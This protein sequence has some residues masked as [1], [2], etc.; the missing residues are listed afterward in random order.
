MRHQSGV[1]RL[2]APIR[3]RP[4]PTL[5]ALLGVLGALAVPP[6]AAAPKVH[7]S[8]QVL[9]LL[10]RECLSC[11]SGAAAPGGFSIE[12]AAKLFA[13]G[14]HGA[15]VVPGKSGES[16]LLKY[17][18]GEMK[19]QM[20][21]GKPLA[22]ETIGLLKRWIDEGARIDSFTAAPEKM[23]VMRDAMPMAAPSGRAKAAPSGRSALPAAVSQSAP[24]TAVAFS[25][26]GG[27]LA[28]G[29]YR[30]VRLLDSSTG[31]LLQT[32]KG[33]AGQ[34]LSLAW[35]SDGK[36]LA[37]AGGVPSSFGELCLWDV[38]LPG[39]GW[40]AP[41][42]ARDHTDTIASVAWRPG[43]AELATASPDRTVRIWDAAAL[44]VSRVLKDHADSVLAVAY[45]PDGRWMATGSL[46]RTVKLY[47]TDGYVRTTSLSHGDGVLALAFGPKSDIVASG[48]LDKQVRVWPVKEGS[49][50]NPLRSHGEGEAV[51]ALAFSAAGD[52]FA[53]GAINR[54][55][56][57]FNGE[58]SNRLRE[59]QEA[60]DWVYAV[61]LSPDGKRV[62]AGSGEGKLY[63]WS[64]EDGKRIA[65]VP[66]GAG[67]VAAARNE[68]RAK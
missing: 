48:C 50:E 65:A 68:E 19:P 33:P 40:P 59:W 67:A 9:P 28:A 25:P 35:S 11:H 58:V 43:A 23:G 63:L 39:A 57:L 8:K 17:L 53:W 34:V 12:S 55:V 20:P 26:D 31:N 52:R 30:A 54:K 6:T 13:G 46:D 2:T 7:F 45:S 66:L 51:D 5:L 18:T 64:A 60:Q 42:A 10:R 15:A 37:A 38:P 49:V 16:L 14:R 62:A 36:R 41:R 61:T 4:W 21:P 27:L 22:L 29:G 24:V 56:Q 1:P 3:V 47:R 44:K 32:L